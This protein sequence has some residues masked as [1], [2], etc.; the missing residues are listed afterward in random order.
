MDRAGVSVTWSVLSWSACHEFELR[1]GRTWGCVVLEPKYK[2]ASLL[3]SKGE[4]KVTAWWIKPCVVS[5]LYGL[6]KWPCIIDQHDLETKISVTKPISFLFQV[7]NGNSLT[8]PSVGK[9]CGHPP[10][11]HVVVRN[12][13]VLIVFKTDQSIAGQGFLITWGEKEKETGTYKVFSSL[14]WVII[15]FN[16]YTAKPVCWREWISW[17]L[18]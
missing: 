15:H 14:W 16:T 8:S 13:L 10:N 11:F 5:L 17:Q 4:G 2:Y 1:L 9:Y 18:L 12:H 3:Y 6:S 7:H